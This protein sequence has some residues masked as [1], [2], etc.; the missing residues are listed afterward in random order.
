M[1]D[2]MD[3][4]ARAERRAAEALARAARISAWLE[5]LMAPALRHVRS[6]VD[7]AR[8]RRAL[9]AV[10]DWILKDIGI[11]RCEIEYVVRRGLSWE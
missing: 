6:W 2:R 1:E 11:S 5:S 10:D 9:E 8:Q 7:R 3:G 4:F